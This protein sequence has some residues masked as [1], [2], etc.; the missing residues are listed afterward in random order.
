MPRWIEESGAEKGRPGGGF[1]DERTPLNVFDKCLYLQVAAEIYPEVITDIQYE[2][3]AFNYQTLNRSVN[4]T[5]LESTLALMNG[6]NGVLYNNDIFYDRQSL[7]D[8]LAKSAKKWEV[9]T[10]ANSGLKPTGVHCAGVSARTIC[11]LGIPYSFPLDSAVAVLASGDCLSKLSDKKIKELLSK[12]LLTDGKGV[13]ILCE[14]GFADACGGKIDKS[15][16]NSMAERFTDHPLNGEYANYY[17]DIFMNFCY[18]YKNTGNAYSFIPESG[19]EII[20][21]LETIAHKELGCSF[22]ISENKKFAADGYL[23]PDSVN[24]AAKRAQ[25]TNVLDTLSGGR[26]PIL[27]ECD[28]KI[29]PCVNANADGDMTVMLTNASFDDSGRIKCTVRNDKRFYTISD[30]GELIPASQEGNVIT[31][32]NIKPWGYVLLT[33]IC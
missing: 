4:F 2:Y 7:A 31:I 22:Y 32:E 11:E 28:T 20:S 24:T 16:D 14:R 8:M 27:L 29:M 23:F 30:S 10:K 15:Y 18:Y 12:S 3:E 25:L 17:R 1:Y 9:L 5:E 6:C 19:A 26:L 21:N 13:E 33:N